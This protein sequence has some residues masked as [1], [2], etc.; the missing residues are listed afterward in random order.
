MGGCKKVYVYVAGRNVSGHVVDQIIRFEDVGGVGQNQ[1]VIFQVNTPGTIKEEGGFMTF[2]P[3]GK[4]WL[5]VGQGSTEGNAEIQQKKNNHGKIFHISTDG[6]FP[7]NNP[8]PGPDS[9]A[10]WAYGIRNSFGFAF[11]P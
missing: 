7:S 9:G 11:D 3:D 6:S 1:Q 5:I 10:V 4:L 2:G 8:F